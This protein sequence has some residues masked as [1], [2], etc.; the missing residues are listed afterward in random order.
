MMR[1]TVGWAVLLL[2]IT[3]LALAQYS[4]AAGPKGEI[5]PPRLRHIII[6]LSVHGGFS[7]KEIV[8]Q[9]AHHFCTKTVYRI[10][11]QWKRY[12]TVVG[13]ARFGKDFGWTAEQQARIRG[14]IDANPD[15]YLDEIA[16]WI[17]FHLGRYLT[18][19]GVWAL[20]RRM[21]ITRKVLQKI[22]PRRSAVA[23]AKFVAR[24]V[25]KGYKME[26]LVFMDESACKTKEWHRDYGYAPRLKFSP[27]TACLPLCLTSLRALP[28]KKRSFTR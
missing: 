25:R 26:Q 17:A 7:A 13:K 24:L 20:L 12:G 11:K 21:N 10:T 16:L 27:A 28:I 9:C 14:Y 6:D 22:H 5:V 4:C 3:L 19:K 8:A 15:S 18:E 23:R 2:T 1:S